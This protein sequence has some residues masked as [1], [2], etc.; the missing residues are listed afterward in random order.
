M[1]QKKKETEEI[2][3]NSKK[4]FSQIKRILEDKKFKARFQ[5]E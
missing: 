3:L 1:S 4:E 5:K 2:I